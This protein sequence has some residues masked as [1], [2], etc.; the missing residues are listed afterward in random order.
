LQTAPLMHLLLRW[1]MCSHPW[2][3]RRTT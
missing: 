2:C 1:L 3:R